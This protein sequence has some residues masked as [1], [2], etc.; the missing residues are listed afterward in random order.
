MD[1][2]Q[3]VAGETIGQEIV[4]PLGFGEMGEENNHRLQKLVVNAMVVE[5]LIINA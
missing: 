4:T 2:V 3:Y 5:T 1:L